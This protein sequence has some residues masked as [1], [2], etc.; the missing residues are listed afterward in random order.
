MHKAIKPCPVGYETD[1]KDGNGLNNRW[2]NLR[3]ATRSQNN[4]NKVVYNPT[5]YTGVD[6]VPSGR[7]RARIRQ[8]GIKTY[9]GTYDTPE[10]AARAWDVRAFQE[11]GEFAVLNFPEEG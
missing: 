6:Q 1:H 4:A 9:I 5:G 11:F 2:D 10:E 3:I 7:W 8:G